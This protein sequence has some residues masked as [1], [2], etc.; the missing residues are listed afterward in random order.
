[1]TLTSEEILED[2]YAVTGARPRRRPRRRPRPV[3]KQLDVS[4]PLPP[5]R[6]PPSLCPVPGTRL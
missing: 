3:Q 5:V 6:P 4:P 2:I 1:V